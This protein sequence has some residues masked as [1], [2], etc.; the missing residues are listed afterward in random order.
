MKK[1]LVVRLGSR[2]EVVS[3]EV[4]EY[5]YEEILE[6]AKKYVDSLLEND[7]DVIDYLDEFYSKKVD[8]VKGFVEII[9]NEE[10]GVVYIE[11]DLNYDF[12]IN[13]LNMFEDEEFDEI[14]DGLC[15]FIDN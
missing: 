9:E 13:L 5:S 12:C 1:F 3:M 14:V 8:E 15:E 7:P 11:Y 10:D 4:Q 6:E 2:S